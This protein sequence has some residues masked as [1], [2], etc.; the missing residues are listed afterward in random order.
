LMLL[1]EADDWTPAATCKRLVA[2]AAGRTPELEAYPGAHHGFDS[3]AP[4]RLHTDVPNGVHP[5]QGVHVGGD[6]K[7][8]AQSR[9]RLLRFLG[10]VVTPSSPTVQTSEP[11]R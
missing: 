8:R 11:R 4:V 3:P 1:G 5:G 2:Q 7:A 9:E 6:P 10:D